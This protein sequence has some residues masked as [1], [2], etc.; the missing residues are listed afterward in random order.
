MLEFLWIAHNLL[1]DAT[2]VRQA[3]VRVINGHLQA[4]AE[5]I[6]AGSWE[7]ALVNPRIVEGSKTCFS[8]SWTFSSVQRLIENA[9]LSSLISG[10]SIL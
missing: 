4:P 10:S 1:E 5:L 3:T 9:H 7:A 8:K 6:A 2:G